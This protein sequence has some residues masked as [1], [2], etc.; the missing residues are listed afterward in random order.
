MPFGRP[1]PPSQFIILQ[2]VFFCKKWGL[3]GGGNWPLFLLN[4]SFQ[5][6]P[7]A[8][9]ILARLMKIPCCEREK[10]SWENN[11]EETALATRT[12]THIHIYI[13]LHA[14]SSPPPPVHSSPKYI[15]HS[16]EQVI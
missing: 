4:P 7:T 10:G 13:Y 3:Q 8:G 12:N 6:R 9:V 15:Y 2:Y 1:P 16:I 5:E 14:I 11:K